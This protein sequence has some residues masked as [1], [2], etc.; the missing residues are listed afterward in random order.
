[1]EEDITSTLIVDTAADT[2]AV[3]NQYHTTLS[4]I[5]DKHAPLITRT[6]KVRPN[7]P[8]YS[9][10][11]TGAKRE[12]R[13]RERRWRRTRLASDL[14]LFK[15]QRRLVC[16]ML[17]KA[18]TTYYHNKITECG[19]DSRSLF[20]LMDSLLGR[21]QEK[22]LP[23]MDSAMDTAGAFSSYFDE[24]I[25]KI[26]VNLDEQTANSVFGR[27]EEAG[28]PTYSSNLVTFKVATEKEVSEVIKKSA[29]E[30]YAL[31]P[32]PT[33][34]LK[35][36]VSSLVPVITKLVNLSME[37]GCVPSLFKKALVTPLLKKITL[38]PEVMKNYRPVSN[39][40]FVSKVLERVVLRRLLNH[41][42]VT[43]QHEPHQSAY[44]PPHSTE[45]AL[46]RVCNDILLS[47]DQRKAVSLVLLDLSA[48]FDT[49]DHKM[50]LDRLSNIG[51]QGMAHKWFQSYLHNRHQ[52][53]IIKGVKSKRYGV[54]Q[55]SVLGPFLFTQYTVQIGAI[56]RKH[57]VSYQLYADDT[58]IYVTFNIDDSIDRK[59]AL[60]KIEKC[61]AEIRAWMVIHRLKLN[62]DKTEYV[63]LVL[64]QSG[65]DIDVEPITIGK[66]NIQPT[67][68]AR[69]IGV[70]FDS[71]LNMD[72][73]I[74][75]VCQSSY[76]W[77]RNIRPHQI[78]F[79][80]YCHSPNRPVIGD[81]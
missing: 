30:T 73:Q 69:N 80:T 25:H 5:L 76:F 35:K 42:D 23:S 61:I 36:H 77:L 53:V 12:R 56:C 57:G 45:T 4:Q 20:R 3:A 51:V 21:E 18:K 39:L 75:K 54:P 64:S 58:H 6:F 71:S 27:A 43:D 50:L 1:M 28:T 26:R 63:Y 17:E 32:I 8:W 49:I 10:E 37:T 14:S 74:G 38:N 13:R 7:V 41:L 33:Q 47:L 72:S 34:I 81:F 22:H 66:S 67:T 15:K 48:A 59:I 40:P 52:S 55:G 62:D 68:S 78:T 9:H 70:I 60:T 44:R 29:T 2:E 46:V 79:N 16:Q 19:H 31:N 24:K 65:G 11:I